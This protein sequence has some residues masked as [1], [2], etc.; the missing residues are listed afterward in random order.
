MNLH[1]DAV[2]NCNIGIKR[3]TNAEPA[4]RDGFT[5]ARGIQL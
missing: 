2:D 3:Q 4:R 5:M 1:G